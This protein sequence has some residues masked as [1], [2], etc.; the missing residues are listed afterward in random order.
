MATT[1]NAT[2]LALLNAGLPLRS[3]PATITCVITPEGEL[4]IDPTAEEE[5]V[6]KSNLD[7]L[8]DFLW[9]SIIDS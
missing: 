5:A 4:W 3:I 2:A 8:S 1:L 9:I 6:S 7:Q